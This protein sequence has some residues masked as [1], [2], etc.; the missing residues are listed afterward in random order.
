MV[1]CLRRR[2]RQE[3][4]LFLLPRP[5]FQVRVLAVFLCL[6]ICTH[7]FCEAGVKLAQQIAS[8]SL[9][10][11]AQQIGQGDEAEGGGDADW[12]DFASA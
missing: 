1:S 8:T 10:P 2:H 5:P 3:Q 9:Q 7:L 12:G 6:D 11:V 4:Q